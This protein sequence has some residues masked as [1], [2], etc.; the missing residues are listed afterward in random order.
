MQVIEDEIKGKPVTVRRQGTE[1]KREFVVKLPNAVAE[2][3]GLKKGDRF[4][5][6]YNHKGEV[7]FRPVTDADQPG[8][9]TP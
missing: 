8:E 7:L 2:T 1:G 4:E 9:V 6:F 5:H 3:L